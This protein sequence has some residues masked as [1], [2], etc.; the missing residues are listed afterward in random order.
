MSRIANA[1]ER[2]RLV[3]NEREESDGGSRNVEGALDRIDVV[4]QD[5]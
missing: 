4:V 1:N 5:D 3:G 2:Q